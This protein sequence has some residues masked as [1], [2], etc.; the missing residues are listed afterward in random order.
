[1]AK[2]HHYV[3]EAVKNKL[4]TLLSAE[5]DRVFSRGTTGNPYREDHNYGAAH[6]EYNRRVMALADRYVDDLRKHGKLKGGKLSGEQAEYFL[7][8][9]KKDGFGDREV[10]NFNQKVLSKLR[11]IALGGIAA[12]GL[13]QFERLRKF[14]QNQSLKRHY[15]EA[16]IALQNGEWKIAD[17]A[18]RG[19]GFAGGGNSLVSD[20]IEAG[21]PYEASILEDKWK[22][23]VGQFRAIENG[24]SVPGVPD[25]FEAFERG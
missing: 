9:I 18:I 24:H 13:G 23:R 16:K 1:M 11:L 25:R 12:A 6:H 22:E 3:P 17:K 14:D 7:G 20:L 8:R 19:G 2:G 10:Y 5:A 15:M 4:K 21:Y